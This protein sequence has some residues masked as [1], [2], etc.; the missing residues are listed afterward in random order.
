[1]GDIIG[2]LSSRRAHVEGM[3]PR[4]GGVTAIR[5]FV[6]LATMFGYAT[7]VR[8]RHARTRNVYDGI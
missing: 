7:D 6:P 8:S 2:D 5:A 3:E 4:M 1:M